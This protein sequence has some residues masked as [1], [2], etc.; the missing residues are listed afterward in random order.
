[1]GSKGLFGSAEN[2][3]R[4]CILGIDEMP[5]PSWAHKHALLSAHGPWAERRALRRW[6]AHS[7]ACIQG[8]ERWDRL[9]HNGTEANSKS[10][11]E[12]TDEERRWLY[13]LPVE[14]MRMNDGLRGTTQHS[15]VV[16]IL[17]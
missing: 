2:P 13:C 1:M 10:A 5:G 15:G 7:E 14:R 8:K 16:T 12:T 17:R 4:C 3:G 6:Q 11:G 9:W